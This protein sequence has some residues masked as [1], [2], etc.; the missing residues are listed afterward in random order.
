MT[1]LLGRGRGRKLPIK[2]YMDYLCATRHILPRRFITF[3][4]PI[5]TIESVQ[6]EKYPISPFILAF[7]I[8]NAADATTAAGVG[9]NTDGLYG[10]FTT[11]LSYLPSKVS[12]IFQKLWT[13]QEK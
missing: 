12:E 13:P 10:I 4:F 3:N 7:F 11:Y 1:C 8:I 5:Y 6:E 2:C 9:L